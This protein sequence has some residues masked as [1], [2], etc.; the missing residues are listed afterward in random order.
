[1]NIVA[2]S[3]TSSPNVG[4]TYR[5]VP[6]SNIRQPSTPQTGSHTPSV[7]VRYRII[8]PSK[9]TTHP[10]M[11]VR[12]GGNDPN[13]HP[14]T[15]QNNTPE[16]G[17]PPLIRVNYRVIPPS[18]FLS[19]NNIPNNR[20]TPNRQGPRRP[21]SPNN[22]RTPLARVRRRDPSPNSSLESID[23][24][25]V[26]PLGA[27][28]LSEADALSF[29]QVRTS[30]GQD[31]VVLLRRLQKI[32]LKGKKSILDKKFLQQCI[33]TEIYPKWLNLK[34]GNLKYRPQLRLIR[35]FKMATLKNEFANKKT[36]TA[37]CFKLKTQLTAELNTIIGPLVLD[38]WLKQV[39]AQN[40]VALS[41]DESRHH[42]K[43]TKLL[44]ANHKIDDHTF[45][46]LMRS[47]KPTEA[48]ANLNVI[49]NLSSHTLNEAEEAGLR[50]GLKFIP[51][52]PKIDE[53]ELF[54][55]L[56]ALV[57][58][59]YYIRKNPPELSDLAASLSRDAKNSIER[60]YNDKPAHN[61]PKNVNVALKALAKNKQ[62]VI[63]KPDKGNGVVLLNKED[64]I[65][66]MGV[67][68]GDN[69]KFKALSNVD[70]YK[71]TLG[72]E[73]KIRLILRKMLNHNI[74][75]P[76]S[77]DKA[78]P[79]GS[80]PCL[81]YG[82]PKVHKAG[83]PLRPIM[84]A[85]GSAVHGLA[86]LLV[87]ILA[88]LTT[89][90]FTVNNSL[91]FSEELGLS[92][93]GKLTLASFDISSLFTNIPLDE[94]IEIILKANKAKKLGKI[95]NHAV[96]KEALEISTKNCNFIF[97]EV[98]YEQLDGVAMG[99]PL[100]P[101]LANIFMCH[102]EETFLKSATEA[103]PLFYKRYVDDILLG[104]QDIADIE[105]FWQYYNS[106]H[107]N[108]KF[109]I[110]NEI[111]HSISFLDI[112]IV[113]EPDSGDITT[114]LYRKSTF[115]GLLS[116]FNTF[117]Y[118]K[119]KTGLVHCLLFRALKICSHKVGFNNE[120]V[121]LRDLFQKNRFPLDLFEKAVLEFTSKHSTALDNKKLP[122]GIHPPP[123]TPETPD[124]DEVIAPLTES[125][126]EMEML[127]NT[128]DTMLTQTPIAVVP[129]PLTVTLPF[130]G[131]ASLHLR[132]GIR[133]KLLALFP[134]LKT[135]IVFKSGRP[136]STLFKF[137][138]KVPVDL[139]ANIIYKYTCSTC[140]VDYIG[141]TI[142]HLRTRISE[143]LN[144]SAT[145]GRKTSDRGSVIAAHI[146]QTGHIGTNED[147]TVFYVPPQNSLIKIAET[148]LIQRDT[149][150]LND[151][152]GS[153]PLRVYPS[154]LGLED[155]LRSNG[156][157]SPNVGINRPAQTQQGRSSQGRHPHNT[158]QPSQPPR[159][160]NRTL[161]VAP[162]PNNTNHN[163]R[164]SLRRPVN[165]TPNDTARRPT[166]TARTQLGPSNTGTA[167]PNL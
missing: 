3:A 99:S 140:N 34:I 105:K 110:E 141:C 47:R 129:N 74:I 18:K 107:N 39:H 163:T 60:F 32:D 112:T 127:V 1:M 10:N 30:Y 68:L 150:K 71:S 31:T 15:V 28:T 88:P 133:K 73:T 94:T 69:T 166:V 11:R 82:L 54:S 108:I 58:T 165:N 142:R 14:S 76:K 36:K 91:L 147:F 61:L 38:Q 85:S 153:Y 6:P 155:H 157:N 96:L 120:V 151:T 65:T 117:T 29:S 135:R 106:R 132:N 53:V 81:L 50:N 137:K 77:Y 89:N 97:N 70:L 79:R 12:T 90:E 134:D 156:P 63:S 92:Q 87:P 52:A 114:H 161:T 164:R 116:K 93:L 55:R 123:E 48:G 145:T 19:R 24:T 56:E 51:T 126:T 111:N 128:Q 113:R 25:Q 130:F 7:R 101:T 118:N 83:A 143:H 45:Q 37:E 138:D 102:F 159:T 149:P 9:F 26:S 72:F 17:E 64:Y 167:Q 21:S 86:Q 125:Q 44:L 27:R 59:L 57:G 144:I 67:V 121:Y 104:F 66:K 119:Y 41:K 35:D 158:N 22:H 136:L 42:R 115:T 84:S 95:L 49:F 122:A 160:N 103:K 78:Y 23:D 98:V 4:I 146:A 13:G 131:D 2:Q 16:N 75:N 43:L 148:I 109:T 162:T 80:R 139:S 152:T 20:D 5:V 100:G 124:M 46:T 40:S 33:E 8:P 154:N 62:L